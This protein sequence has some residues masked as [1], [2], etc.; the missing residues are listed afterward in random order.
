MHLHVRLP[1][2]RY[3]WP[4]SNLMVR[5]CQS[6]RKSKRKLYCCFVDFKKAFDLVPRHQLAVTNT[7]FILLYLGRSCY[8]QAASDHS[9]FVGDPDFCGDSW[10][11]PCRSQS[12]LIGPSTNALALER[13]CLS[14]YVCSLQVHN[15]CD[16][17]LFDASLCR[18]NPIR[19]SMLI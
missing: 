7:A 16:R 6:V 1:L 4:Q 8:Y 12:L 5:H 2:T 13:V 19:L 11:L 10:R 15:A 3:H 17:C 14:T 18:L 9:S